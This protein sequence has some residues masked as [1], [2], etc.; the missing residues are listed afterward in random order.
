MGDVLQGL[1]RGA[2]LALLVLFTLAVGSADAQIRLTNLSASAAADAVVDKVDQGAGA[3]TLLIR[4]G[5]QPTNADDASTGTVLA[6]ITF[7]DPAFG[8]ATNGVASI[9]GTITDSSADATGTAGHFEVRDSNSVVIFRGTVTATGGGGQMELVTT[10]I[11]ATQPVSI[12][13]FSYTQPKS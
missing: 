11:T 8:A 13:A 3:G 12:T 7:A 10:A 6:T 9:S 1:K 5:A 4:T 2:V